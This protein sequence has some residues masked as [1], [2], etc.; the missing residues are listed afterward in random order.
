M[1]SA[2]LTGV[3][4]QGFFVKVVASV[5]AIVAVILGKVLVWALLEQPLVT[6]I[7]PLFG[8]MAITGCAVRFILAGR[9][10]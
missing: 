1:S 9:G 5:A 8:A 7:D 3:G 6:P 2:M 10:P 4:R